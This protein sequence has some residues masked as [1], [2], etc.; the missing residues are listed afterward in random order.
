MAHCSLSIFDF[1]FQNTENVW[2]LKLCM[3]VEWS[4]TLHIDLCFFK[5]NQKFHTEEEKKREGERERKRKKRKRLFFSFGALI[6]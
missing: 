2:N 4:T 1:P 5:S 6:S 3:T